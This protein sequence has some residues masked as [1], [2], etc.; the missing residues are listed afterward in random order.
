MAEF[1]FEMRL[2]QTPRKSVRTATILCLSEFLAG[3]LI[4][5]AR[6]ILSTRILIRSGE[7]SYLGK[8]KMS[9]NDHECV[10]TVIVAPV[11]GI[12]IKQN[13]FSQSSAQQ[14]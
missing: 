12:S 8:I 14:L 11:V 13:L 4:S 5:Q 9:R 1:N 10:K 3:N 6:R 7:T 2:L